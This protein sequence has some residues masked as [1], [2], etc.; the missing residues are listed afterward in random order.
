M[1][2]DSSTSKASALTTSPQSI[3][4]AAASP[5]KMSVSEPEAKSVDS[6]TAADSG[7][8]TPES[9]ENYALIG[10]SLR[11]F[12]VSKITALTGSSLIWKESATPAGHPW[13]VL[14]LSERRSKGK[15]SSYSPTTTVTTTPTYIN[16]LEKVWAGERFHQTSKGRWRKQAKTGVTGSMNWAQEMLVRVVTQKNPNLM[17]TPEACEQFMGFPIG[18]T[19]LT[20]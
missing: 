16:A 19:D 4:S 18:H 8:N 15:G 12:L 20:R 6:T 1:S 11:T 5:A 2:Q 17:P 10:S 3:S 14:K 13:W 9:S 7:L